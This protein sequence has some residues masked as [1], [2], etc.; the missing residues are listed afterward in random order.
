MRKAVAAGFGEGR[1]V[2]RSTAAPN[3]NRCPSSTARTRITI[4]RAV[5]AFLDELQ[6]TA[7]L[8]TH[9]K[10]RLL[11]TKLNEFSEDARLRHDRP[12][13]ADRRAR[14]P[15]HLGRQSADGGTPHGDAEAVFR[16]LRQ[17]RMDQGATRRGGSR[18]RRAAIS[19]Q[20]NEQKLPF[21]DDELKRMYEACPEIRQTQTGTNGT[22][23]ML[24]TSSR[25]R[26]I[27]ASNFRC[28][29][30]SDRPHATERR[31]PRAHDEGRHARLHMGSAMASGPH[32][33]AREDTWPLIFGE[34]T[35]KTLMLSPRDGA[36][37][38]KRSGSY[39]ARGRSSRRRIVSGIR[40]RASSCKSRASPSGTLRSFSA[41]PRT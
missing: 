30:V 40:L 38:C 39:A 8:A 19:D 6:E 4:E 14:V 5:K 9:K 2:G 32:P 7:A 29:A 3:R 18:T 26:S 23:R 34:H 22:A 37:S 31:N 25:C 15:L 36:E 27:R 33:S 21:T 41:T 35:T 12:V 1:L 11:M 17:Q 24:P 10:Y 28:C 20:R 16:I 13:G